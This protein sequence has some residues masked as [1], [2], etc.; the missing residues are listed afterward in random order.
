MDGKRS[1]GAVDFLSDVVGEV[2]NGR[3]ASWTKHAVVHRLHHPANFLSE[4]QVLRGREREVGDVEGGRRGSGVVGVEPSH[5]VAG[6]RLDEHPPSRGGRRPAVGPREGGRAV[7]FERVRS[8]VPHDGTAGW[9]SI[10]AAHGGGRHGAVL[11]GEREV[12]AFA[13][14]ALG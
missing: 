13:G 12:R 6:V 3:G 5:V 8:G 7:R 4:G 11:P 2:E 1:V 14:A 10:H 9:R